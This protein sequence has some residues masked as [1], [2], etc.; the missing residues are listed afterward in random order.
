M[1]DLLQTT[2]EVMARLA[3]YLLL[4]FVVA[5]V[6]HALVPT[7]L[8]VGNLGGAGLGPVVRA[9]VVGV[10]LPLCSCSV[11]P[12]AV[13]LRKRG[14]GRG[15]TTAFLISTPETGVDSIATSVAVLHPLMVVFR[16][17]AALIT[18]VVS[19]LLVEKFSD[20]PAPAA[21]AGDCCHHDGA[22]ELTGGPKGLLGGMRY[23]FV[24]L[25]GEVAPYLIPA[26]VLTA[27]LTVFIE[28]PRSVTEFIA[29]PWQQML[30]LLVLGVPV[31]VCAAAATPVAAALILA[32]FS[33]GAALVFLLA[34]P[35]TN[36][37]TVS[38]VVTN[39][40]RSAALWYCGAIAVISLAF[41]ALLDAI[42][43]YAA[44]EPVAGTAV[45][46]EHTGWLEWASAALIGGLVAW[47]L[48]RRWLR[49]GNAGTA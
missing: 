33:P 29:E 1:I 45:A 41:G 24:D 22:A 30:V 26:V 19:G 27:L 3:P 42:Y 44:L 7:Q 14:A 2:A 49:P 16:P 36:L 37:M 32:G 15:A 39:L 47:H 35:A 43:H 9:A 20:D 38:A 48:W 18:A 13:E 25:F 5:G 11:V 28:V 4:G 6:L 8:L 40:G 21:A 10:P 31:Y 12:V 17:L 23:A 46:H 34:G